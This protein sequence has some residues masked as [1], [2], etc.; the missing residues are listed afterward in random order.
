MNIAAIVGAIIV[1]VVII[2]AAAYLAYHQPATSY[3]TTSASAPATTSPAVIGAGATSAATTA[4]A[5]G[6]S[7]VYRFTAAYNTTYGYYLSNA[8]G[9]TLYLYTPDKQYSNS[10]A[11][12]G[13]CATIWPPFIV[14][15]NYTLEVPAGVNISEFSTITRTGG[16]KQLAYDGWPLYYYAQ[17]KAS[18]TIT[19]EGVGGV[20]YI[21]T[22]PTP[23][24]PPT[25]NKSS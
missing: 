12:Y 14:S 20:W 10:S 17:D 7:T 8:T 23:T 5:A 19:G 4:T 15:G 16:E 11:C 9:W 24:V 25:S 2:A 22:L 6:T 1:V 18:G 13:S 3:S 21:V